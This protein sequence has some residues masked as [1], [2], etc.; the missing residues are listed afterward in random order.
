MGDFGI[1]AGV[2]NAGQLGNGLLFADMNSDEADSSRGFAAGQQRVSQ[3]FAASQ[4]ASAQDFAA[5]QQK[6][7]Q[8]F[9]TVMRQTAWQ[10]TV[11]D[12][13]K[14]GINP[15]LMVS[16]G[17]PNAA[18]GAGIAGAG[19]GGSGIGTSSSQAHNNAPDFNL[20]SAYALKKQGDLADAAADK[21]EAEANEIR[22]RTPTHEVTRDHM[23]QDIE[24]SKQLAEKYAQDIK[25]GVATA[26]NLEQQ[27]INA[28][29]TLTQIRVTIQNITAHT[30]NLRGQNKEIDQRLEANIPK[31]QAVL[32]GLEAAA[33]RL[34]QPGQEANAAAQSSFAGQLGAYLRAIIPI[35]NFLN[36]AK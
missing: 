1:S 9:Q 19:I 21:T 11:N 10:D 7:A 33:K 5:R 13:Q 14:A 36:T 22:E 28:K 34:E 2:Q 32:K 31:L 4:Q 27:T 24:T 15:M 3:D 26:A 20:A 23:R 17:A 12:M 30:E 18:P 8:G 35:N 16:H 29:E 6:D 25:T